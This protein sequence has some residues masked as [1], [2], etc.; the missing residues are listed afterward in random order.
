MATGPRG[1]RRKPR[2]AGRETP[3]IPVWWPGGLLGNGE[4]TLSVMRS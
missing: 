4:S 1:C 2:V 3:L